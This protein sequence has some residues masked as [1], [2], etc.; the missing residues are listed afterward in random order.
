[1]HAF[2]LLQLASPDLAPT[3]T[4]IHLATWNGRE[5]P[6][7][8]Y[9]VGTFDSWQ[10]SQNQ[11]NFERDYVLSL[12]DM[13]G[14]RWLFAG[15]FTAHGVEV[16]Q[17]ATRRYFDYDLRRVDACDDLA[18]R[19]VVAFQRT[20]RQSYLLAERWAET[21]TVSEI[22]PARLSIGEFPGFSAVDIGKAE[23]DVIVA[24]RI[25]SWRAALS[26]VG[27]VY[28]ISDPVSGRLYV[29]SAS[30]EG[31]IWQRWASYSE[32]GHGGNV[33]LRKLLEVDGPQRCDA[34]RFS[35]LEIADV[36]TGQDAILSR[37]SHWKDVL[38]TR[39]FGLNAN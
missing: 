12:I 3:D 39:R 14:G 26:S 31:G 30:G 11:R 16:K 2:D 7:D 1:M 6:L 33:E 19:L 22:L 5:D 29:G 37:E 36:A 10:A 28:L 38:M 35:I 23:L 21:M 34:F 4:K 13:K 25:E 24:R 18:G 27:G 9:R 15:L 32:S 17:D 20:G 8:L